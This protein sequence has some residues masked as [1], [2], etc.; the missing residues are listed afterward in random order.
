ME[1]DILA[2]GEDPSLFP[3]LNSKPDLFPD[4]LW[5][6]ESFMVLSSA[7][8]VGMDGPQSISITDIN[9][10]CQFQGIRNMDEREEL[11]YHVQE[12]DRSFR[13]YHKSKTPTPPGTKP[14]TLGGAS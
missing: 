2:R 5:I 1:E 8:Q 10:L 12:M 4:L 9:A 6:W 14:P 3:I 11:L 7:R 13:A